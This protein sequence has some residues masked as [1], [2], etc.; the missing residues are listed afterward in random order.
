MS[1]FKR[2]FLFIDPTPP[3]PPRHTHH[4]LPAGSGATSRSSPGAQA[5]SSVAPAAPPPRPA[6]VPSLARGPPPMPVPVSSAR[7]ICRSCFC[8][9][10]SH[11]GWGRGSSLLFVV[12]CDLEPPPR[13][14]SNC[15]HASFSPWVLGEGPC[16]D[17][18]VSSSQHGTQHRLGSKKK[19]NYCGVNN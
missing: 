2:S 13:D 16:R 19:K 4:R 14:I 15:P 17:L 11:R 3:P 6:S 18:P 1:V 7:S 10:P 5:P 12:S 8:D 9:G